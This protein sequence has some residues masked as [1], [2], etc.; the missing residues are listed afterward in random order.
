MHTFRAAFT[1][2]G[3]KTA[4][5]RFGALLLA[6]CVSAILAPAMANAVESETPLQKNDTLIIDV[7]QQPD[8]SGSHTIDAD[9][10]ITLPVIGPVTIAGMTTRTA[11]ETIRTALAAGPLRAP[12]VAILSVLR[13]PIAVIGDVRTPGEYPYRSGM[14][15]V[16][17]VAAAG[18]YF[19]A[20]AEAGSDPS[21]P[22]RIREPVAPLLV[23]IRALNARLDRLN[24][25]AEGRDYAPAPIVDPARASF[26]AVERD[27]A[28]Q[29]AE[30]WRETRGEFEEARDR[31]RD[32][33][34][35]IEEALAASEASPK[36]DATQRVSRKL[37]DEMALS[38]AQ[39]ELETAERDLA[40]LVVS[41]SQ[42]IL[43]ERKSAIDELADLRARAFLASLSAGGAVELTD[44]DGQLG[45]SIRRVYSILR[46][47]DGEQQ[48][49]AAAESSILMP[50][51]IVR[52]RTV[53]DAPN[54]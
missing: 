38:R 51:D 5:L 12:S 52:V 17:A 11:E 26:V 53:L 45:F 1:M 35:A 43:E 16:R 7:F 15:V 42:T 22:S 9:G 18:G 49:I 31:V 24:A 23:R 47:V 29:R 32:R 13:S 41:R 40:R 6:L 14:R 36:G 25:E 8:F 33:I 50:G 48:V 37:L 27:I 54:Q 39:R 28:W 4:T 10:S 19:R 2:H 21:A 46:D 3:L 34:E 44:T 20:I 30:A